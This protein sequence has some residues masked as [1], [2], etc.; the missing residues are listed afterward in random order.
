LARETTVAPERIFES[1]DLMESLEA[2][3]FLDRESESLP[4]TEELSER[5]R[6]GQGLQ[7]PEIAVLLAYA[8][9]SLTDAV[10]A[11]D[12]VD[13]PRFEADLRGYFPPEVVERFG[14][15]IALHPLRRELAATLVANDIV[16]A[17][18]PTYASSLVA[19]RGS[20]PA[21]VVRAYRIAVEVTGARE[22]WAAVEA[23]AGRVPYEVELELMEGVET[24]VG[25]VTRWYA[26]RLPAGGL[27]EAIEA[28][29]PGF[30]V[31]AGGLAGLRSPEWHEERDHEA[32]RLFDSGVPASLAAK[33]A[34]QPAL[35]HA[36]DI[37]LVAAET[38]RDVLDVARAFFRIG[39]GLGLEWL[40]REVDAAPATGRLQRWASRAVRDDVLAARRVLAERALAEAPD[41]GGEEA[42]ER[43]LLAREHA[44]RR[45]TLFTR[46]LAQEGTT[47]L[48]ALTLAVRHLR[49][50]AEEGVA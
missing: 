32:A 24:L 19:E 26:G 25:D 36:P 37:L 41:A 9:R 42:V 1:E 13:D 39:E 30:A 47:D 23:L 11:S 38:G 35:V 21:D 49:A 22:R 3:G 40:E 12:L 45:L 46:A 16:D 50:L 2:E 27:T 6:A 28:S 7:R 15:L 20:E 8:K 5:R 17:L 33:H 34:L 44:R 43:F 4:G 14:H 48:A 18:G 31:L 29:A 10:L